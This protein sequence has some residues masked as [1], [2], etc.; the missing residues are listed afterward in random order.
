VAYKNVRDAVTDV[1]AGRTAYFISRLVTAAEK[2]R[3]LAVT[4][5]RR[6]D[7]GRP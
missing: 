7:S 4:S 2:F 3:I 5:H 6:R 1:I